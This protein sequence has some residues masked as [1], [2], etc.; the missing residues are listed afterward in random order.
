MLHDEA[1]EDQKTREVALVAYFHRMTAVIF[2]TLAEAVARADQGD[3]PGGHYHDDD[4]NDEDEPDATS[5]VRP[6]PEEEEEE[7][8]QRLLAEQ[9]A[10]EHNGDILIS[11][12]DMEAMGLDSWSAADKAFVEELVKLWWG[13]KAVVRTSSI[14]CCGLRIM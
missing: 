3:N 6:A 1:D 4:E 12:E 8:T 10:K 5:E 13:R 9:Q 2:Q 7:E 14:E 11:Q